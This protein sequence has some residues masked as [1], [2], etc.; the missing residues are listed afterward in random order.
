MRLM[1]DATV[2]LDLDFLS[3]FFPVLGIMCRSLGATTPMPEGLFHV[4]AMYEEVQRRLGRIAQKVRTEA[5]REELAYWRARIE[6]SLGA[7]IEKGEIHEAGVQMHAAKQSE[8]AEVKGRHLR[9]AERLYGCAIEAGERGLQ[10]MV[11]HIRDD[12]DRACVAAYYHFFVREVRE[13]A[14]EMLTEASAR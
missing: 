14:A 1:E 9:E 10:A 13:K 7:L 3:L 11:G 12:S 6:F 4:R 5:G 2:I 8:D